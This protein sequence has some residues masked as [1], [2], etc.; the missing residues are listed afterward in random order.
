MK[1]LIALVAS[2]LLS[3]PAIAD[4]ILVLG[5]SLTNDTVWWQYPSFDRRDAVTGSGTNLLYTIEQPELFD[6][7]QRHSYDYVSVQPYQGTTLNQDVDII[8]DLM[9][10]ESSAVF[11]IHPGWT[12]SHVFPA[13]YVEE[14]TVEMRPSVAYIKELIN[15]LRDL[16]PGREI[17]SSRSNDILYSIYL[18]I[19]AGQAPFEEFS[20][21]FRDPLHLSFDTGRYIAH[22]SILTSIGR[23]INI[24]FVPTDISPEDNRLTMGV[25]DYLNSKILEFN[26]SPGGSTEAESCNAGVYTRQ[27]SGDL[28]WHLLTVPCDVPLGSTMA[29]L[30]NDD[31]IAT[32][33]TGW[34]AFVYEVDGSSGQYQALGADSP[35]PSAGR[36]F[37]FI[38]SKDVTLTLPEGSVKAGRTTDVP[39]DADEVCGAHVISAG[40]NWQLIGNPT[41]LNVRHEDMVVVNASQTLNC[42][43]ALPCAI[44]DSS[45]ASAFYQFSEFLQ[46]YVPY[47]TDGAATDV[48]PGKRIAKPWDGYWALLKPADVDALIDRD[49]VLYQPAFASQYLFLTDG[50]FNGDI[51]GIEGATDICNAE[52]AAAGLPGTYEPWLS[53]IDYSPATDWVRSESAYVRVDGATVA[54]DFAG[55]SSALD[56]LSPISV[57]AQFK[58][59]GTLVRTST[60]PAGTLETDFPTCDSWQSS[61]FTTGLETRTSNGVSVRIDAAW[62]ES[63]TQARCNDRL[64]IYCG[65][66]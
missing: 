32:D 42:T 24:E 64:P 4:N 27:V 52:S 60:T 56:L 39:C 40:A 54:A 49:W 17:V 48:V 11:I 7:M 34:A 29:D 16:H 46:H 50:V 51:G 45:I 59:L 25:K 10:I 47:T 8:S 19:Q 53:T 21:L 62:T 15:R 28:A 41:D 43:V 5:N 30:I 9:K 22:N 31:T 58:H 13:H 3:K 37:W 1:T 65:G 6:L 18:D 33:D 55:L 14:L 38:S 35:I 36:G 23:E 66:Q 12:S 20:E 57:T 63:G 44:S 2:L 61:D 26:P